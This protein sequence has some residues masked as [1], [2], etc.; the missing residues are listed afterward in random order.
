M[1]GL[2]QDDRLAWEEYLYF[3]HLL[4]KV[5]LHEVEE[6]ELPVLGPGLADH[7]PDVLLGKFEQICHGFDEEELVR[8]DLFGE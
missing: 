2:R 8:L 4:W 3:G 5:S 6:H 7:E 1:L